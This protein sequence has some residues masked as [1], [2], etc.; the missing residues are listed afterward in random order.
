MSSLKNVNAKEELL[1][2]SLTKFFT[3]ESNIDHM[4]PI[5]NGNSKISLRIHSIDMIHLIHYQL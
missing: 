5:V 4:L 2:S 3:K 1:M